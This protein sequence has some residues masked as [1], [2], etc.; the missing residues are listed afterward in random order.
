MSKA[1]VI[2]SVDFSAN[3]V[4]QITLRNT[5]YCT[6]ITLNKNNITSN[7]IDVTEALVATVTPVDCTEQVIWQT[8]DVTVATVN[9][10]TVTIV[11][12]GTATITVTCG[13]YSATCSVTVNDVPVDSGFTFAFVASDSGKDYAYFN[14]PYYNRIS[15]ADRVDKN[16]SRLRLSVATVTTDYYLAPHVFPHGTNKINVYSRELNNSYSCYIFFFSSNKVSTAAGCAKMIEK[17]TQNAS[18]NVIDYTVDVP[19]GADSFVAVVYTS[20]KYTETDDVD[21]VAA[22][23]G[24]E[25]TYRHV[26]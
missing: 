7:E 17:F 9:N 2:K 19:D 18:N 16:T 26:E 13:N 20:T 12:L 24:F 10:G 15:F 3:R 11:G 22:N 21:T 6:G 5:V 14:A 8:S 1:L 25:I 23:I 4:E